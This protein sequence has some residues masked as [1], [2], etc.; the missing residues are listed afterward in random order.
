MKILTEA[1]ATDKSKKKNPLHWL[2]EN[3]ES[4]FLVAGMLAIIFLITWQV[5][6][7]YIIT[8]FT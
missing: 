8:K 6:Y 5:A 3:F 1:I 2:D 4:I 7:R